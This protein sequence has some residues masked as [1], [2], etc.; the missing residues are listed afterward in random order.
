VAGVEAEAEQARVHVLEQR[1]DLA[2][3]LDVAAGVGVERGHEAALAALLGRAVR[4]VEQRPPAA[5]AQPGLAVRLDRAGVT[6]AVG[7][8]DGI[9]EQHDRPLAPLARLGQ[10][11]EGSIELAHVL[12]ES[13]VTR[14]AQRHERPGQLHVVLAQQCADIA[15]APEISRGPELAAGVPALGHRLDQRRPV[16]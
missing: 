16:G 6:D 15:P 3:A 14:K 2:R 9:R 10:E 4:V 1:V 5:L 8:A 11:R 13:G 7:L 12:G